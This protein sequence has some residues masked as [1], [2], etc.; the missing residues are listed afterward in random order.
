MQLVNP[1]VA[2]PPTGPT[3]AAMTN[4]PPPAPLHGEL[5]SPPSYDL[6]LGALRSFLTVLVVAHHAVL[7]YLPFAPP[8]AHSLA[9]QPWWRA[10]PVVDP[11]RW[12][13]ASYLSAFNDTFFMSLM[14]LISGLFVW[15]SLQRKG[16]LAFCRDRAVR[17]GVPFLFAAVV[18]SPLAYLP[19]HLQTGGAA[20]DFLR[21]WLAL[22][23][24]PTGPAWFLSLLLAFDL[25]IATVFAA[26]PRREARHDAPALARR[27]PVLAFAVLVAASALLYIPLATKLSPLQWTSW[28]PLTFQTARIGHYALYFGA[29]VLIGRAGL[30]RGLVAPDGNLARRWPLWV[31][32]AA[33]A[34]AFVLYSGDR[35]FMAMITQAPDAAT[36]GLLSAA[37]FVLSCAASSF[38]MLAVFLRFGQRGNCVS[39]SLIRSAFGIYVVHYAAVTWLQYALLDAP[40]SG[41]AK[42]A[43]VLATALAVSWSIAAGYRRGWARLRG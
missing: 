19:A 26:L 20:S 31:V 14:F 23:D 28:G 24:W 29:G 30:G 12:S 37:G 5:A 40:L 4:M 22:G 33:G 17:L 1:R 8:P 43:I 36:W 13:G 35:A 41:A 9:E 6:A 3:L 38:A 16:A 21:Q 18:I 27:H 2:P 15:R 7:A 11:A 25:V 39:A 10:F 32:A 34:L 42:F